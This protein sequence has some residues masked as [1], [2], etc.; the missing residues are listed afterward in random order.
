MMADYCTFMTRYCQ[1][2]DKLVEYRTRVPFQ[3]ELTWNF[4]GARELVWQKH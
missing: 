2:N 4:C 3:L 1:V